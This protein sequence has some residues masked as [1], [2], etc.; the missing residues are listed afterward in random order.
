[1]GERDLRILLI[2]KMLTVLNS[3]GNPR[4]TGNSLLSQVWKS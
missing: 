4:Q 2:G 3:T 1:M